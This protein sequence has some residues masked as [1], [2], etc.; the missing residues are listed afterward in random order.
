MSECP[1]VVCSSSIVVHY[2]INVGGMSWPVTYGEVATLAQEFL[3]RFSW[4]SS[5][6]LP[7]L[8]VF[9]TGGNG[10]YDHSFV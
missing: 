7:A 9:L 4:C 2:T 10:R 1:N 5:P 6:S 8:S 3:D